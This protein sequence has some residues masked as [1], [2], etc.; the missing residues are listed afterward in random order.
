MVGLVC[1]VERAGMWWVWWVLL[2]SGHVVGLVCGV[3]RGGIRGFRG[4]RGFRGL[5]GSSRRQCQ[6]IR[7]AGRLAAGW[8]A[9]G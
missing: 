8:W 4:F 6:T 3:K 9:V 5:G 1:G 2:W 7:L